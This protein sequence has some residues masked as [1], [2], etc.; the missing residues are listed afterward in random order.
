[1]IISVIWLCVGHAKKEDLSFEK[2]SSVDQLKL[3]N[4]WSSSF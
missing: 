1:M 3:T 4:Y 2:S